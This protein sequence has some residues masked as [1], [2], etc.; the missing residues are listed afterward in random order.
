MKIP[1]NKIGEPLVQVE[2]SNRHIHLSRR[3]IDALFGIGYELNT[4]RKLSQPGYFAAEEKVSIIGKNGRLDGVRII[5]PERKNSQVELLRKDLEILG[6]KAP[7]RLS[8]DIDGTPGIQ[9]EGPKGALQIEKGVI[10]PKR[11]IHISEEDS[12]RLGIPEGHELSLEL[13]GGSVLDGLSVRVGTGR[14]LAAHIDK[15]EGE[16]LSIMT[17]TYGRILNI[18]PFCEVNQNEHKKNSSKCRWHI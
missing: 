17:K 8:G 9:L 11:H 3:D 2:V 14:L 10:L 4:H 5:G 16:E 7:L 15:D 1:T 18:Q 12:L 13:E 6:V